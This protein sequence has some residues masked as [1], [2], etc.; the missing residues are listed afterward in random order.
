MRN[1]EI[2]KVGGFCAGCNF[3]ILSAK[4]CK[5][6]YSNVAVFKDIVHNHNV[7]ENLKS[8]GIKM[9]YE[10]ENLKNYRHVV[11]RA[12]GEPLET[13]EYLKAN[14]V[15]YTDCTCKNVVK[16]HEEVAK[17]SGLGYKI[18]I[19]GKHGNSTEEMHPE[20]AGTVGWCKGNC[21]IVENQEDLSLLQ[22][23]AG[24]K[25]YVVCQTTF[26]LQSVDELVEQISKMAHENHQELI[27]NKSICYAQL[28]IQETSLELASRVDLMI[29]VGS[30]KSSN[31]VELAKK[32]SKVTKTLMLE[33]VNTIED[34]LSENNI[35]LSKDLKIGLTAG[36]SVDKNELVL[37]QNKLENLID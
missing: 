4:N 25:L 13:Y 35:K 29:V 32:L 8:L 21:V 3:A 37:L 17:Y 28:K 26:D 34:V 12:H 19:I 9:E 27:V 22:K 1:I 33:D 20:V 36:A 14:H 2:C 11:L 5:Q 15:G 6:K 7:V 24:E 31:S 30:Q 10:L 23:F 18:V 16:I